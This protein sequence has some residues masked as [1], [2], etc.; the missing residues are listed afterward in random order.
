MLLT[1]AQL[2]NRVNRGDVTK[3]LRRLE[4]A[5]CFCGVVEICLEKGVIT[6]IWK[7]T[8]TDTGPAPSRE[9]IEFKL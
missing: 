7:T 9:R 1:L 5:A 2:I 4:T 3:L 8:A 6:A